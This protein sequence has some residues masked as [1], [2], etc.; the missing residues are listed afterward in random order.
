MELRVMTNNH[1][2]SIIAND[3]IIKLC[4]FVNHIYDCKINGK[5]KNNNLI[6]LPANKMM[7][8]NYE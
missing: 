1:D 7:K 4:D 8:K 3:L 6:T 2:W 5:E